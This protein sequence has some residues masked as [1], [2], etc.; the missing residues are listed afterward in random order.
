MKSWKKRKNWIEKISNWKKI[1]I[2]I[3]WT[4]QR[5]GKTSIPCKGKSLEVD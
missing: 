4:I 3:I 2:I 1:I 5:K